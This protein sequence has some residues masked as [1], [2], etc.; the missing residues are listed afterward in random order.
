MIPRNTGRIKIIG[1]KKGI[2]YGEGTKTQEKTATPYI[3]QQVVIPDDGY[4]LSQVTIEA[5]AY[6]ETD[7]IAG[8]KTTSIGTV[9][10]TS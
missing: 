6:D 8:G 3:T 4:T 10:P 1:I 7:N 5:I 9:A 2:I